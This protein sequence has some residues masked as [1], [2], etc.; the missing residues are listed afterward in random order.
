MLQLQKAIDYYQKKK[1][2]KLTR[3]ELAQYVFKGEGLTLN[4][5]RFYISKWL[6]GER[7]KKCQI[8]HLK[9]ISQLTGYSLNKL[10]QDED[11]SNNKKLV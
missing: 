9:R 1:N 11:S 8:W 3:T 4:T 10:T 2:K 6:I 7:L 5:A